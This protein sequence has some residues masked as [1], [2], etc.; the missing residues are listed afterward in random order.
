MLY[1][2]KWLTRANDIG[3]LIPEKKTRKNAAISAAVLTDR[4]KEPLTYP[5]DLRKAHL[6]CIGCLESV[7]KGDESHI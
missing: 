4:L 3:M 2:T 1:P 7:P 6:C 5:L